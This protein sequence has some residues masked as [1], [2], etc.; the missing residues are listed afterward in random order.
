MVYLSVDSAPGMEL[1]INAE[2]LTVQVQ[3]SFFVVCALFDSIKP[4]T[5]SGMY[6][7]MYLGKSPSLYG[8]LQKQGPYLSDIYPFLA[9]LLYPN[10]HLS[11]KSFEPKKERFSMLHSPIKT[12]D[13]RGDFKDLQR[14]SCTLFSTFI[15]QRLIFTR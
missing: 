7:N 1:G 14:S 11:L 15:S 9:L 4:F 6:L 3:L 12:W 10:T 13:N 8:E 2:H 5:Y